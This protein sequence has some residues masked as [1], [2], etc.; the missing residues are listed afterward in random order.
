MI[1]SNRKRGRDNDKTRRRFACYG[2]VL[3]AF[4]G[5]AVCGFVVWKAV[6]HDTR[7]IDEELAAI[8]AELAVP[9][10]E[11]AVVH[12]RRFFADSDN[13]AILDELYVRT[14]SAYQDP[15]MDD[16]YPEL[17][18]KLKKHRALIQTLLEITEMPQAR[19]PVWIEPD[20]DWWRVLTNMR[21]M[22]FILSWSAANDLAEGR[23]AAAFEKYQGQLGLAHQLEQQP[24]DIYDLV[25]I[26]IEA[27]ALGNIRRAVMRPETTPEQLQLL[28]S[29]VDISVNRIGGHTEIAVRVE[30]LIEEKH[31]SQLPFLEKLG[32]RFDLKARAQ[33]KEQK[34]RQHLIRLRYH[35]TRRAL[36]I[37]VS[38]RRYKENTG[39][40]PNTLAKLEPRLTSDLL[41]DPQN[42]S[43]FVYKRIGDSFLL[44]SKGPNGIDE[45]GYSKGLA[46]DWPIWPPKINKAAQGNG[47][48]QQ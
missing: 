13:A 17:A 19:L 46:D 38:L 48:D 16:E 31:W 12:Y 47:A 42:D 28:E 45:A 23:S 43:P 25:G 8:D 26:A 21:R 40:W 2:V 35:A 3:T 37:L 32:Q 9:E 6:F 1:N 36:P 34:R 10:Q 22:T 39:V 29:V 7:S 14:P 44:Y 41:I 27:V 15:W 4:V 24:V 18:T 33:R 30:R 5:V 20:S 11:N